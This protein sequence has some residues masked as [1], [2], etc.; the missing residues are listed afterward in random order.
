MLFLYVKQM[1]L[2]H[3]KV[4]IVCCCYL[5]ASLTRIL[6]LL[7]FLVTFFVRFVVTPES[8]GFGAERAGDGAA[9]A[10]VLAV[11]VRTEL[12]ALSVGAA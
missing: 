1:H 2:K 10:E 9:A 7:Q 5:S 6:S 12:R 8:K 3:E 4:R 11:L